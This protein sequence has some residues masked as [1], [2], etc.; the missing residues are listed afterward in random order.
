MHLNQSFY[1]ANKI[2]IYNF[3]F[4][5][6]LEIP[7]CVTDTNEESG[8][9]EQINNMLFI[10]CWGRK[11]TSFIPTCLFFYCQMP[12]HPQK[13][14]SCSKARMLTLFHILWQAHTAGQAQAIAF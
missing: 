3:S 7:I 13:S 6:Q 10:G 5:K 14:D 1:K 8:N 2:N 12:V 9:S 4:Y 11:G